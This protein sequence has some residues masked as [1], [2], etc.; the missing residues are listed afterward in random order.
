M[1]GSE[2]KLVPQDMVL[3]VE[4]GASFVEV[5]A[6]EMYW[7]HDLP[8]EEA[9]ALDIT[10]VWTANPPGELDTYLWVR[11]G[12]DTWYRVRYAGIWKG[13]GGEIDVINVQSAQAPD[14]TGCTQLY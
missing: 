14:L 13:A 5:L 10:G 9:K 7:N 6:D 12:A 8:G 1:G 2:S 3:N 11:S 4:R